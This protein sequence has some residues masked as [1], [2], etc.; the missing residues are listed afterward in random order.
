MAVWQSLVIVLGMA[1][2]RRLMPSVVLSRGIA[3]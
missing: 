2:G 1:F 3:P